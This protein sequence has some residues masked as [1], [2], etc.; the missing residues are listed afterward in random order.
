MRG[1][2]EHFLGI[3]HFAFCAETFFEF[4]V[5]DS[6]HATGDDQHRLVLCTIANPKSKGFGNLT[7]LHAMYRSSSR[8]G[9]R[10]FSGLNNLQMRRA[11]R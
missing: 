5:V 10:R 9:R 2:R 11:A 1:Q 4:F 7:G 6:C 3:E 8:D